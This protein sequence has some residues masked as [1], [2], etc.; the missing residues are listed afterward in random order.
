MVCGYQTG[1]H[2]HCELEAEVARQDLPRGAPT[3]RTVDPAPLYPR[4]AL[5]QQRPAAPTELAPTCLVGGSCMV[6]NWFQAAY[7]EFPGMLFRQEDQQT[8]DLTLEA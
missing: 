3:L 6:S 5:V 7:V 2:M 1:A 8:Y 4:Q